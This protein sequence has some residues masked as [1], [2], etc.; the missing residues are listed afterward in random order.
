LAD[1]VH[2]EPGKALAHLL[3]IVFGEDIV[4]VTAAIGT[5]GHGKDGSIFA[6]SSPKYS[7]AIKNGET[8]GAP[9]VQ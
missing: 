1:R 6:L 7:V 2:A 9:H 4:I 5:A 8:W 3:E